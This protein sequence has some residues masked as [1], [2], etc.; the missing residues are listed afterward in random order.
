VVGLSEQIEEGQIFASINQ[1]DGMVS[2]NENPENYGDSRMLNQLDVQIKRTIELA[3]KLRTVDRDI[4]SSPLYIQKVTSGPFPSRFF[5][6]L[7]S[8]IFIFLSARPPSAIGAG[9]GTTLTWAT[10]TWAVLAACVEP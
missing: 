2:F 6:A 4:A 9:D 7:C 8:R 5:G 3:H 10:S 1:K